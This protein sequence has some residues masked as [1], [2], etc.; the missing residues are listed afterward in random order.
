[1]FRFWI[2]FEVEVSEVIINGVEPVIFIRN[3]SRDLFVVVGRES[4]RF[5]N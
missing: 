4:K 1:M 2:L 5:V 3:L